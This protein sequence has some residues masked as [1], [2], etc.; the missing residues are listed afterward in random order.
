MNKILLIHNNYQIKGGEDTNLYEEIK[1]LEKSNEVEYLL[2]DNSNKLTI[3]DFISFITGKNNASDSIILKKL[4][5]FNPDIVYIH[6]IWF[7]ISFGIF[8]HLRQRQIK[9]ILKI[10]NF[11]YECSRFWLVSNHIKDNSF[12]FACSNIKHKKQIFNKYFQESY[13]KSFIS[14]LFSKR[15]FKILKSLNI[16]IAVLSNFHK[17]E[18]VKSGIDQKKIF[19][20]RNTLSLPLDNR[21]YNA[22]S[23]YI[24]YAGRL[25]QAKGV[26]ELLQIWNKTSLY[27]L[28]LKVVGS[29]DLKNTLKRKY[30]QQNIEFCGELDL[31]DTINEIQNARAVITATKMY[32][33]QPRILTEASYQSVPSIFPAFGGMVEF[34]PDDYLLKFEQFN[35]QSLQ[36]KLMYLKDIELMKSLSLSVKSKIDEVL[37]DTEMKSIFKKMVEN[38]NI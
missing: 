15:Y 14:I 22:E 11:R 5:S 3:S 33:G 38:D 12:C 25:N 19:I 32:E 13:L 6:N 9:T 23:N 37:S 26:E 29:G 35:Y 1:F 31:E 17:Q 28:K 24:V 30:N 10:H 2:F 27:D 8:K 34:F 21:S 36:S 20:Y 18:L 7:K 16:S 4:K